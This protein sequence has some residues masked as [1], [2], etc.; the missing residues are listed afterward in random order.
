MSRLT[1]HFLYKMAEDKQMT[2]DLKTL[3]KGKDLLT[4]ERIFACSM[5]SDDTHIYLSGIV[6]A[7]MKQKFSY[8]F[9]IGIDKRTGDPLNSH[10]ECPAGKGPHG[11]CNHVAAVLLMVESFIEKGK[12]AVRKGCTDNLQ[13]F[14]IPKKNV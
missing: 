2:S 8:N 7:A 12:L 14:H 3:E 13:S 1:Y 4:G 9:K 10:C 11:T 5:S 6:G